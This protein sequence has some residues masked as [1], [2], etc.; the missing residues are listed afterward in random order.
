MK[1]PAQQELRKLDLSRNRFTGSLK[2][3]PGLPKL[4]KLSLRGNRLSG[5]IP[6]LGAQALLRN[7]DLGENRFS[8]SFPEVGSLRGLL[9]LKVDVNEISGELS[10]EI[11]LLSHSLLQ[12]FLRPELAAGSTSGVFV[13]DAQASAVVASQQWLCGC[14]SPDHL[15]TEPGHPD[16]A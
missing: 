5:A 8:G 14:T 10:E 13:E 16:V 12:F 9:E 6:A 15:S 3:S 11:C 7:V 1:L 4:R 2:L